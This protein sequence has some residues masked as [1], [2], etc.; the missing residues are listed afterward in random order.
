MESAL[1]NVQLVPKPFPHFAIPDLFDAETAT[2]VLTWLEK[3]V[4]WA[5]ESRS[6]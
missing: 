4:A 5:I 1:S 2:A 3:D 6:F